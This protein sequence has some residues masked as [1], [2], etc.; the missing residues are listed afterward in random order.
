MQIRG[1][2]EVAAGIQLQG[3]VVIA[4][5]VGDSPVHLGSSI[6]VAAAIASRRRGQEESER[7]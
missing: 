1:D 6:N 3:D 5:T 4:L 7:L 2:C